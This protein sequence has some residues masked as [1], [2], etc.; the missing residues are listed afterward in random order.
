MK[1]HDK[2]V[3]GLLTVQ[4]VNNCVNKYKCK[5]P[6][7]SYTIIRIRVRSHGPL[8]R[9]AWFIGL[10]IALTLTLTCCARVYR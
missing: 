4:S 8:L 10:T 6:Y 7:N 2:F 1:R 5:Y 9:L 3:T